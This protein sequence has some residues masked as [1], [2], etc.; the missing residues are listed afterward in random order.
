[1]IDTIE[2][3]LQDY[4]SYSFMEHTID[5][6]T[7]N[8]LTEDV[9]NYV[10]KLK[11]LKLLSLHLVSVSLPSEDEMYAE[12]E[13]KFELGKHQDDGMQNDDTQIGWEECYKWMVKRNES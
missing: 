13:R 5:K 2:K 3:L 10:A 11:E 6:D 12:M 7:M 4:V 9:N 1:M 8:R